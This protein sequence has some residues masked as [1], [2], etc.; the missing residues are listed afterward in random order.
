MRP[1][2][3]AA[4]VGLTA[5]CHALPAP[6][7]GHP[8][9]IEERQF[10][11][12]DP[13]VTFC[14]GGCRP[15]SPLTWTGPRPTGGFIIGRDAEQPAVEKRDETADVVASCHGLARDLAPS[16]ATT[17]TRLVMEQ[18]F[19][20]LRKHAL[21]TAL[22]GAWADPQPARSKRQGQIMVG[23]C[24]EA[25][26][27]ALSTAFR[28]LVAVYGRENVPYD[29]AVVLESIKA[30]LFYCALASS[31]TGPAVPDD[32]IIGGPI[33]P[34]PNI[35]GGPMVPDP[36][37]PGGPLIPGR[38]V[39]GGPIVPDP[40]IPGGPLIPDQPGD[41]GPIVPDEPIEGGP[42]V[43]DDPVEGGP[44]VPSD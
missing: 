29:V 26:I 28:T 12:G 25:D 37:I 4:L 21:D 5:I 27:V 40:T 38:P 44:I 9:I 32:V 11:L 43:P 41:G 20:V 30:A 2:T 31:V 23:A 6:Q 36:T 42:I 13:T 19:L 34:D 15:S 7:D 8:H 14:I 39:G 1:L 35:P 10:T 33:T 18:C 16:D 22:L 3:A 24:T 17:A